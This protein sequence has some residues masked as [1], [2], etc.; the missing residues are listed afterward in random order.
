MKRRIALVIFAAVIRGATLPAFAASDDLSA[1]VHD[2]LVAFYDD[3]TFP[4]ATVAYVLSDGTVGDASVGF[5]DMEAAR[6]MTPESR[7]L[8]ASI[9]KTFVGALILSLEEDGALS[10]TDRVSKYL[11]SRE[12]YPRL[13][14]ASAITIQHLLT[15]SA[16]L[17]DHVQMQ[18]FAQRIAS[19]EQ[20]TP[21]DA[22][23]FILDEPPL[24]EPGTAWSYS[25]TGYL[26]LGLVIE[27]ATGREFYALVQER[28]LDTLALNDTSPSI[29]RNLTKLAVGY[30]V[31]DNPFGLPSRT[32]DDDRAL[33]WNPAVEWTGGGF[34]ST[35]H[36]L[37]RWGDSLFAETAFKAPDIDRLLDGVPIDPDAP[38]ILY[39]SG[40]AIYSKTEFGPV[41]GHGGWVPGYVSSLRHYADHGV[42]IAFQINTDIGTVDESS[43]LV[44]AL[45]TALAKLLTNAVRRD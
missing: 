39:G 5:D 8:A 25:D 14:N 18:T 13:P 22:I 17:P 11:G 30:T 38:G 41:Y 43:N 35:S 33:L 2:L 3:Y 7:M 42:T 29:S 4:G 23:G 26:L 1:Q 21:E 15:H 36:D 10:R 45:E 37:A 34:A 16:G 40:V 31:K 32:M 20:I 24:F 12:W 28:F 9:G 19:R 6:I 44:L 27:A